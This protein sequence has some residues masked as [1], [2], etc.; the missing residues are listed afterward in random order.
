MLEDLGKRRMVMTVLKNF[1][2]TRPTLGFVHYP[3]GCFVVVDQ[4][5][6]VQQ[7]AAVKCMPHWEWYFTACSVDQI[8]TRL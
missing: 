3:L 1:R 2:S 5:Q 7:F 8:T 6:G 4:Q